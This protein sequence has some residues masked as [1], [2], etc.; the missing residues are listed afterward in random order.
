MLLPTSELVITIGT[1]V[2]KANS[3]IK[4]QPVT[5]EASISKFST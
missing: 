2:N 4:T 5:V 3:D 1:Q